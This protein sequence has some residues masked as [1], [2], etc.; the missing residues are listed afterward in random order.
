[1][2]TK[3]KL[4]DSLLKV[5]RILEVNQVN[6]STVKYES[7]SIEINESDSTQAYIDLITRMRNE[8]VALKK[9]ESQII[10][11]ALHDLANLFYK[12]C[13]MSILRTSTGEKTLF[14]FD[15]RD[16]LMKSSTSFV[17]QLLGDIS[18]RH[19]VDKNGNIVE[20]LFEIVIDDISKTA[21]S[22]I[23]KLKNNST[24]RD[25][26]KLPSNYVV[27][28]N[29]KVIDIITNEVYDLKSIIKHYDIVNKN[30]F[31]F[32]QFD[33]EIKENTKSDLY[34]EII[35]RVMKDWSGERQDIEYLLWQIIYAILQNNNHDRFI[36]LM[37]SGGNGKSTYMN[38]LRIIS[39][40][41]NTVEAN[42]HQFNDPNT[43]NQIH[44]GT[45]VIIGDDSATNH[46]IN[47]LTLSNLKSIVTGDP[48]SVPVKYE[49]NKIVQT[50]ALMIQAT[51]TELSIFENNAAVKS[52]L[53]LIDWT[54][55]DFRSKKSD[56]TFDLKK[57]M[58]D[59]SFI[60]EWAMVCLEKVEY[61]E[62]FNI[63]Q[64]IKDS[65]NEMI[66]AND[67]I[68]QFLDEY[69]YRVNKFKRLPTKVLYHQYISWCK[70]NN[71]NGGIMKLHTFTKELTKRRQ[72]YCYEMSDRLDRPNF[73]NYK[74][75]NSILSLL[76]IQD[77]SNVDLSRQSYIKMNHYATDDEIRKFI[78][79]NHPITRELT[80]EEYQLIELAAIDHYR[81][82]LKSIYE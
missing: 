18:S 74:Y 20:S 35:D 42:I 2:S 50:N 7:T 68:K 63:P 3:F 14:V 24:I 55:E 37:G 64:S 27:T 73:K 57:L 31:N 53:I 33:S 76:D 12:N 38:I 21:K 66:E 48:I 52:R 54:N 71:P 32:T 29:N 39:G 59:Q 8:L 30:Y 61:F 40:N 43:I 16:Y 45:K 49:Q 9:S 60:D 10:K 51:N 46:K 1:M 62:E 6:L 22:L 44:M 80:D 23:T 4:K 79:L 58:K 72:D 28:L 56:L 65:T 5:N 25:F 15:P 67:T 82:D 19:V 69:L 75:I 78:E 13:H 41:E 70:L 34:R 36:I 26:Y 47:N 81:I 17:E 11:P 77:I